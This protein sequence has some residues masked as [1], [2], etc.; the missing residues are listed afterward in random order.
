[1]IRYHV[2]PAKGPVLRGYQFPVFNDLFWAMQ[3]YRGETFTVLFPR[4]A[5]KNQLAAELVQALLRLK[6][7]DGGSAIAASPTFAPQGLIALERTRASFERTERVMLPGATQYD[8][9][10]IRSWAARVHF[11]SASPE[12]HVAGHTASIALI[13][14]E[15]QEIDEQW[16]ERQFRPMAASTAAN[17]LLFGTPWDG[18]T[19]LDT[20]VARNRQRDAPH[21]HDGIDKFH[22]QISW[23][24]VG[25]SLPAYRDF[26]LK[27]RDR[28]GSQSPYFKTQYEL[29]TVDSAG[30][31]FSASEITALYGTH[32][33]QKEP[34]PHE[35]YVAGLDV[36]G[37]GA[38]ADSSVLT[39]ARVCGGG[40]CE[41][42]EQVA[43][44]GVTIS[45]LESGVTEL[46]RRWRLERLVVDSTGLGI[47]IGAHLE[48]TLA[49][50]HVERFSFTAD[51]KS[52]LGLQLVRA[53]AVGSLSLYADD[54]SLEALA[55]RA[56]LRACSRRFHPGGRMQWG[57]DNGHDD[58]VVSLALALRAAQEA[59]E[60]RFATGR[61]RQ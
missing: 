24:D 49:P 12:A 26:V 14:D 9:P 61:R 44:Q 41:V 40:R 11:L 42:V 25:K 54:G 23:E 33:R 18:Q 17:T 37:E 30:R 6:A 2:R 28:L 56:E 59:G 48:A 15:A 31:L 55:C 16:F 36:A 39:I 60:P 51:S 50:V 19:M 57:D 34:R 8:G 10:T 58:Y 53:A 45:T 7:K 47:P 4:Q 1:M 38:N 32:G 5:G 3:R 46:V 22:Y 35:R 27:E 21:E 20:A 52:E 29:R 43:W 13:A